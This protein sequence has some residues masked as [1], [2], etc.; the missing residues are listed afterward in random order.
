M[1]FSTEVKEFLK[2]SR[3][4][5]KKKCC[6]K[7]FDAGAAGSEYIPRCEN[8][9]RFYVAGVFYSFGSVNPP[10]KSSNLTLSAPE[11]VL[12][13]VLS[14]LSEN[15]LSMKRSTRRGKAILY[16]RRNGSVEDILTFI[17]A[18]PHS[19]RVMQA[20]VMNE[21]K[22]STNRQT[23]ADVANQDRASRASAE[24]LVAIRTLIEDK[25]LYRLP[26]EYIE[27][28][29]LRLANPELSIPE[30][31]GLFVP[32]LSKSGLTHRLKKLIALSKMPPEDDT[33]GQ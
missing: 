8:C 2:K 33:A 21:L 10:E 18:A 3:D 23:N 17:G 19:V 28:A 24:Q 12:G 15:E 11:S 7:A 6:R 13:I 20:N 14:I 31:A 4:N 32:E 22:L 27:T 1:S 9:G 25:R 5:T 16:A 26:K 29:E 30:L